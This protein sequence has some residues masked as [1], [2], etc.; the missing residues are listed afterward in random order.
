[1]SDRD[2]S[3]RERPGR[4]EAG[5]L[6]LLASAGIWLERL[7]G[8]IVREALVFHFPS[9]PAEAVD[10][11]LTAVFYFL[12]LAAPVMLW[13]TG[14]E[15]PSAG[16]RLSAPRPGHVLQAAA[17]GLLAVPMA[18]C[19]TIL[20]MILLQRLGFDVSTESPAPQDGQ[21]LLLTL[22]S[23][24]LIGPFCEELLLRSVVVSA[25]ERRG[26]RAAVIVSSLFFAALHGSLI[27]FPAAM[28]CGVLLAL[29]VLWSGSVYNGMILHMVYNALAILLNARAAAGPASGEQ[30]LNTD[31]AAALGGNGAAAVL[32]M[33]ALGLAALIWLLTTPMR[34]RAGTGDGNGGVSPE[35]TDIPTTLVL[36]SAAVTPGC[37]VLLD[38]ATRMGGRL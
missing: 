8:G 23:A 10:L 25:W 7:F 34:R 3:P 11:I 19:V 30:A 26:R 5:V 9:L 37:L 27:E 24:A 20:W 22:I 15:E 14:R 2:I 12:F 18:Q 28:L 6:C 36:I 33:Y 4:F 16:L 31:L 17:A 1:M 29:V 21:A 38:A 35:E 32:L 13:S